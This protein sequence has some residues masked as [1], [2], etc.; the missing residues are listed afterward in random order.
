M[1]KILI[2]INNFGVG[3]AERLV[4]DQA[5]ELVK[6]KNVNLKIITLKKEGK[7]SLSE[8]LDKNIK[9]SCI[10]FRY[11]F[12]IKSWIKL[13]KKIKKFNPDVLFTHLW[14]SNTVG[15]IIGKLAVIRKIISFEHN[16]YD[17]LKTRKMFIVDWVL[18]IFSH[19]IIAV[20]CAVKKS[21]I[22]HYVKANKIEVIINGI[23]T[24]KYQNLN[25]KILDG[26]EKKDFTFVFIG[27]LIH[28]KAVDVLLKA[29]SIV[30]EGKLLIVG[31]GADKNNL[32]NLCKK[33]NIEN[34]V[35]FLGIR[36]DIPEILSYSDCFILPSRYEG[37]GIVMLEAIASGSIVIISDFEAGIEIIK[38][39]YNGYV[40][41]RENYS[42]LA[43]KMMKAISLE[44]DKFEKV[45]NNF[46]KGFSV[47]KNINKL[48]NL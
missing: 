32:K 1:K 12:D 45:N 17:N 35:K 3:G 18:Q 40:F 6:R 37:L 24:S 22:K 33:L 42:I 21:L 4:I 20:S 27:R 30:K 46:I 48:I 25:I 28:Q 47:T 8:Q 34:R 2:I 44:K 38:D 41:P 9:W 7:N 13:Y 36:K 23:D 26:E 31:D 39:G 10:N 5:N 15:R 16:I 14:F 29:F 11:D 19:K 43:K